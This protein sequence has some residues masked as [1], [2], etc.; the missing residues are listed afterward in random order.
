MTAGSNDAVVDRPGD[1]APMTEDSCPFIGLHP[2]VETDAPYFRGRDDEI[3]IIAANVNVSPLT[4]L[5]GPSGAGKSSIL[6]AGVVPFL[7]DHHQRAVAFFD[8]W[9]RPDFADA[10]H[11]RCVEAVAGRRTPRAA[12]TKKGKYDDELTEMLALAAAAERDADDPFVR[13]FR[14]MTDAAGGPLLIVLDQF[15][16]YLLG[17]PPQPLF[18]AHVH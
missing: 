9:L 12:A 11:A 15:E 2:F 3:R 13:S 6:Q 14:A 8:D 17:H 5:Y 10:L 18:E 16:D 7:R 1:I 4:V